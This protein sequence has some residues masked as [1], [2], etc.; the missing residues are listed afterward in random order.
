FATSSSAWP[1]QNSTQS[2]AS[3]ALQPSSVID[4]SSFLNTQLPNSH[5][6]YSPNTSFNNEYSLITSITFI[7][8]DHVKQLNVPF[9]ISSLPLSSQ[10]HMGFHMA[11]HIPSTSAQNPH[12]VAGGTIVTYQNN[13]H[14]RV[15]REYATSPVRKL[16][17]DLIKTY[18]GIN[19]SYYARK[20]KR[21]HEQ[22]HHTQPGLHP[23]TLSEHQHA[24]PPP[25]QAVSL[26]QQVMHFFL[27]SALK[28]TWS[29]QNLLEQGHAQQVQQQQ[30]QHTMFSH[31]AAVPSLLRQL[32]VQIA[33]N[34]QNGLNNNG[35][36]DE[37]HDYI[38]HPGEIFYN[39]YVS[40]PVELFVFFDHMGKTIA[41]FWHLL[42]LILCGEQ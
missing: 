34:P 4:G 12:I 29:M 13:T 11:G 38:I 14:N 2:S 30:Q 6:P 37:N 9:K 40:F 25:K 5:S 31:A 28:Q 24:A 36:D 16:S 26:N 35:Y 7:R 15:Q 17:I 39:R 22:E 27:Q 21:R 19:E 42:I 41:H 8:L 32:H 23:A 10:T 3:L 20:A 1:Q 18:K 33:E